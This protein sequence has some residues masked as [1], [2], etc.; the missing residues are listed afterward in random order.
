MRL[1]RSRKLSHRLTLVFSLIVVAI[2]GIVFVTLGGY[3]RN[4]L[5]RNLESR[6]IAV[7]SGLAAVACPNLLR[8]DYITLQQVADAMADGDDLVYVVILDKEGKVAG[9]SGGRSRQGR[10]LDGNEN[11]RALA[12]TVPELYPGTWLGPRGR[13][14]VVEAAVPV[15]LAET[16]Q[17]WG[18]VRVGISKERME[19]QLLATRIIL[20]VMGL[21]GVAASVAA[22]HVL[23]RRITRPL[24]GLV[25]ATQRL[26]RGDR[27]VQITIDSGDEV[28][29]L[30]ARFASS[31]RSLDRQKRELIAARDELTDLNAT[32][33]EKV[34]LRTA[35]LLA[36]REKYRLLVEG[37]PDAFLLL[38]D[39]AIVFVN[40]AFGE[41]FELTAGQME[42]G[43]LSW[44]QVIHKNFHATVRSQLESLAESDRILHTEWI[45]VTATGRTIDLEV[46]GRRVQFL[47]DEV[48]ELVVTDVT[49]RKRLLQ[50]VAQN[51]RLRA[52]GEMTAIVAHHFNNILAVIH[53]RAQLVQRRVKDEQLQNSLTVIQA[54]V[55]K[56]GE[57]VRHLQ[58]Y[59]GEQV[60]MR[61]VEVDV[62]RAVDE[63]ARYQERVWRNTRDAEAP[64]IDFELE[65]EA[66]SPVRGV[67][68]LLQD[69][70]LRILLNASEAMPDG[71]R[72]RIQTASSSEQVLIEITDTGSGM[73]A[74]IQKHLF[75]PFFTTKGPR[76]RGSGS[77]PLWGSSMGTRDASR[78]RAGRGR[79]P[80]CG[81]SSPWNPESR[82]SPVDRRRT[83]PAGAV[84]EAAD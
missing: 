82:G 80:R 28:G 24:S 46:H 12:A 1:L 78:S 49:E 8:Y 32:L 73:S 19:R 76:S 2:T 54:S 7:G 64:P 59:F 45:G 14:G 33:E 29:E 69:A 17:R 6:A 81:S 16:E 48:V 10:H 55:L 20:I 67:S 25:E 53:G 66:D 56:A 11:E 42:D 36:S 70:I 27:D 84:D 41:I 34:E 9:F 5:T 50:Q 63:V 39:D 83:E 21:F 57:M 22:S 52:M 3:F 51:E 58:D 30:A 15:R 74:D 72:I 75:E 77:R 31:A 37:S 26:E 60:D 68:P 23:A 44:R 43:T 62:N 40:S 18:T 65:L 61:F 47:D 13:V 79:A 35:E 38:R 71:G 4:T